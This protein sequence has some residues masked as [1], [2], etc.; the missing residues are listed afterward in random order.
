M[1]LSSNTCTAT[2]NVLYIQGASFVPTQC[3]AANIVK[4][5]FVC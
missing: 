4:F 3:K 1:L 2:S 5:A